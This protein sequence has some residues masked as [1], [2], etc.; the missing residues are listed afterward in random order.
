MLYGFF[1]LGYV[2]LWVLFLLLLQVLGLGWPHRIEGMDMLLLSL[3]TFRLTEVITEEKVARFIRAP[4]CEQ[5]TTTKPDGTVVEEEVPIGKGFRRVAGELVLCPWCAGIW[6]ATLLT[7]FWVLAP[8][9]A[10]M[11][12]IVFGAAA[13]GLLFQ[14]FVKLM[15]RKRKS[16]PED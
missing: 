16:L 5:V 2:C 15:D 1:F 8:G 7:F 6:I 12:L 11:V 9:M 10:R 13:G 14:I 4:F 3:A